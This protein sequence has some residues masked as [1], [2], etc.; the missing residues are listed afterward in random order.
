MGATFFLVLFALLGLGGVGLAVQTFVAQAY[1]A[2]RWSRASMAT[3]MGLWAAVLLTPLFWLAA[4]AGPSILAPFGLQPEVAKL[5][6]DFWL[7]R[8]VG[9]PFAVALWSLSGFFNGIGRPRITLEI[10]L[11]VAVLNVALNALFIFGFHWGIAGSAWATT[12]SQAVAAMLGLLAMLRPGIDRDFRSARTWRPEW[13]RIRRLFGIGV[14][15]GLFAAVD[16]FG[17][18]LF[19]L[20]QVRLGPVDGA[21]TQ[22]VMMLTSAAYLPGLGVAIAAT[23]LVG[24]AIGAGDKDWAEKVGNA[25]IRVAMVYMG[26]VGIVLA[27][28]G[29]WLVAQFV[30]AA[31]PHVAEVGRL[32]ATLLWIAAGY[33]V[34]D[35]LNM[36]ASFCLRGA[37]DVKVPT[38][39]LLG[40]SWFGFVP[41]VHILSFAPGEGFT[42]AL[43]HLGWG[44]VGGWTAAVIYIFVLSLILFARW[45]SGAW[46][47]IRLG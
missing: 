25:T 5:A 38:V 3:W 27:L 34:F 14:P 10:A 7:P 18:A 46:R 33:Q 29:S 12:C 40:L 6:A 31:D 30:K 22:I 23:T 37:G 42:Q 11:A 21:A 44:A 13:R 17:F 43:P 15:T 2:G 4:W 39:M 20:M 8:L 9:G 19:Q 26:V 41:L 28:G 24:Q 16:L 47:R 32:G 45:G 1:G 36:C 35:A